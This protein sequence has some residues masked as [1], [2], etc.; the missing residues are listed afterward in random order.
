MKE[1]VLFIPLSRVRPIN[2]AAELTANAPQ[3]SYSRA[4]R[5]CSLRSLVTPAYMNEQC[6]M[7]G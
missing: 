3:F 2:I 5:L 7:I 1:F 6:H 4:L